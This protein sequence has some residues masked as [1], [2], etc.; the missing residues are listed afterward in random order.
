MKDN[1]INTMVQYYQAEISR[2]KLNIDVMLANP[3][4]I[5][6]HES[7]TDAID[8][9]LIELI[10]ANDKLHALSEHFK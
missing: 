4:A 9:E 2:R 5:P 3:R 1:I 10:N 6:E 8:K 7:F